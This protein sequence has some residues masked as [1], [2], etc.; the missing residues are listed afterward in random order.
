M[1]YRL[2]K[3]LV[4]LRTEANT[5]APVR[6][7]L[8]DG[9]IGDATHAALPSDHNPNSAGVVTAL[10]LTHD[11]KHGFDAH[12]IADLLIKYRHPNL[13]YVISNGRIAGAFTGWKWAPYNGSNPH[14]K[15]I[16]I[17]VGV[18]ED[19]QS[20]PPY[21]SVAKW[22]L[23]EEDMA[24]KVNPESGRFLLFYIAGY[25]GQNGQPN[26]LAGEL[27]AEIKKNHVG[28]DLNAAYIRSLHN[29]EAAKKYRAWL[30]TKPSGQLLKPGNYTVQ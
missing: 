7:K 6:S 28:K 18:G 1:P 12:K 17:S 16:H 30:A 29:S 8:S 19:G 23:K 14:D 24:E 15:H 2:A 26:A 4:T 10:D 27:D 5:L 11:P 21:D 3:S 9:W 13:K 20:K 22:N 25:N